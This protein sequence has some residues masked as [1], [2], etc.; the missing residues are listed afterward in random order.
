MARETAQGLENEDRPQVS[1]L[2]LPASCKEKGTRMLTTPSEAM[3][4][5]TLAAMNQS[6]TAAENFCKRLISEESWPRLRTNRSKD[7]CKSVAADVRGGRML[8]GIRG[9]NC[10]TALHVTSGLMPPSPHSSQ[11]DCGGGMD[12]LIADFGV[13]M[14]VIV[15]CRR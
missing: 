12:G 6:G 4:A 11:A 14:I 8:S 7:V 2:T 13:L 1:G 5:V 3:R 10:T 9:I 15:D